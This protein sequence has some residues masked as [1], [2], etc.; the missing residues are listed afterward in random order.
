MKTASRFVFE[1]LMTLDRLIRAG[2]YPNARTLAERLEVA[3]RTI[4]R[5]IEIARDRLGIP[6]VFD[7]KRRGF[8]YSDPNYRLSFTALTEAELAALQTAQL[9]LYGSRKVYS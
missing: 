3:R 7:A 5:D 2:E 8:T 1:R 9:A 6:L 4:L